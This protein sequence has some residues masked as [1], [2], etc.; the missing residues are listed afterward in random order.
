MSK[1]KEIFNNMLKTSLNIKK[2]IDS[3]CKTENNLYIN[4]L[5]K[6]IL[7]IKEI[8]NNKKRNEGIINII[9]D[10]INKKKTN[11]VYN[12]CYNFF[13]EQKKAFL[14]SYEAKIKNYNP[15]LPKIIKENLNNYKNLVNKK[16]KLTDSDILELTKNQII[17]AT[18]LKFNV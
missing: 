7:D 6:Q 14:A 17:I 15:K 4:K 18:Y 16:T 1:N 10:P 5:E 8:K 9:N 13:I 2:C 11:C 12:N 3:K